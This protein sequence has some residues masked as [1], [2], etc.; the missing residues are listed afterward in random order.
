MHFTRY[1]GLDFTGKKLFRLAC[2]EAGNSGAKKLYISAYSS[3]ESQA[4]CR[5]LGC[6]EAAEINRKIAENELSDIQMKYVL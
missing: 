1:I 2:E 4:A 5:K 3:E 6:V